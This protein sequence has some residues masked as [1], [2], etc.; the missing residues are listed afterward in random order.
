TWRAQYVDDAQQE[1]NKFIKQGIVKKFIVQN[2]NGVPA[3]IAA[4]QSLINQGVDALIIN[5]ASSSA[6]APVVAKAVRQGILVVIDD[7]PATYP[8]TINV[9]GDNYNFWKI[10][11][12]WIANQLHGKGNIVWITGLA[13]NSADEIRQKA[14]NDVLK[15][16]PGI[17]TLAK[18]P[19]GWNET[20]AQ[21][22]MSTFLA[23]YKNIDGVLEQD[24]MAQGVINAYVAN[25][26]PLPI[27]T[28]DYTFGF[29]REWKNKYPNLDT[30]TVPYSPGVAANGVGV[31]VR[32]LQGYKLKPS[33][34]S[35]NPL[36]P[37]LRNTILSPAPF[38]VTKTAQPH[39]PWMKGLDPRTKAIGLDQALKLGKGKPD[40]ASLDAY[41][42]DKELDSLFYPKK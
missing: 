37:Q 6:L 34:L 21:N 3:Q 12:E 20:Q 26:R 39:A 13:G 17:K 30:M 25:K 27:M 40:S 24:V 42:T 5:P 18:A 29:L 41:W 36:D 11:A 31:T 32:L 19:G 16:Y 7:D 23:A 28:G 35:P 33:A 22:V 4:V 38:V 14:A 1:A 15:H 9:T 8:N 10:Q 2:T